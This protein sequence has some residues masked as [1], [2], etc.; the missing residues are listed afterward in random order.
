MNNIII[1]LNG[2]R[3]VPVVQAV[4]RAGYQISTIVIP[5][6]NNNDHLQ[7]EAKKLGLNY[8]IANNVNSLVSINHLKSLSPSLFIIAGYSTI[9]KKDLIDIPKMG[10]INLHA[11]RLP[12]Y[13]GGSPLNW[14]IINGENEAVVSVIKINEGIDTG[15]VLSEQSIMI[16]S[17]ITISELHEEANKIFPKLVLNAIKLIDKGENIGRHQNEEKAKYWHQR[18]DDDGYLNFNSLTAREADR[19]IRALTRP[20]PGAWALLGNKKVRIFKAKIPKLDLRGNSSRVCFIQGQGPY[21]ICKDRAIIIQEYIIEDFP[22]LNLE[23]GN[24]L[25]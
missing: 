16:N 10:V 21:V 23:H 7:N 20:Y 18:N 5:S 8:F 11:G 3:G 24:F 9:F 13:R 1:F 12:E 14:Q 19:F 4:K 2:N 15:P 25:E 17:S 22:D 6:N